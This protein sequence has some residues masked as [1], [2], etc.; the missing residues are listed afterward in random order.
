MPQPYLKETTTDGALGLVAGDPKKTFALIGI[1]SLLTANTVYSFTNLQAL[2]DSGGYGPLVEQAA[3]VLQECGGGV[4][5]LLVK[6]TPAAG[7]LV[8]G[9]Q[10][11]SGL[12]DVTDSSSAPNDDY[13]LV[14]KIIVAGAVSTATFSYS[15]DGGRTYSSEIATAAT[16]AIP[17]TGITVAFDSTAGAFAAGDKYPFEAKGPTYTVGNLNTAIDALIA[18]GRDFSLLEIVGIPADASTMASVAGA[19]QSKLDTAAQNHRPARGIIDGPEGVANSA[20]KTATAGIASSPRV[21]LGA[22]FCALTSIM[23]P[24]IVEKRPAAWPIFA[25]ACAVPLS[26]ALHATSPLESGPLSKEGGMKVGLLKSRV[27]DAVSYS[28]HDETL[29]S[30]TLDDGRCA[31][32]RS[33]AGKSET[34]INRARTLAALA[35]DYTQLHHGRIIDEAQRLAYGYMFQYVGKRLRVN[36]TTGQLLEAEIKILESEARQTLLRGLVN[37]PNQHASEVEF[38]IVRGDNLITTSLLRYCVRVIP[39]GYADYIEG[40]FGLK[41]P[42]LAIV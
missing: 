14:I 27:G 17:N 5:L 23:K 11:G 10:V 31:C 16:Y 39:L 25:R 42:A 3:Q 38:T 40:E 41:N 24:G 19:V 8:A 34:Y 22:D 36:K 7:S 26:V 21:V 32:L 28:F 13:D 9:A 37:D 15:L 33:W 30:T 4:T 18:D 29:A 2:K 1:A 35:S 6:P 12:G 20:L